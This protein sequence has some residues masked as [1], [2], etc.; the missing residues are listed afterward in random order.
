MAQNNRN[1]YVAQEEGLTKNIGNPM[2]SF[3]E[4]VAAEIGLVGY[5]NMDKGWLASRQNGYV[6]G[7]MTKKMVHFAEQAIANQGHQVMQ[8]VAAT[9]EV[10]PE[11]RRLNEM[12]SQNFQQFATALQNG[13]FL[14]GGQET[15]QQLLQ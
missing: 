9:I 12:A 6:G 13:A 11:V 4:E 15:N 2:N 1:E 7:N 10:S 14:N 3:K 8:T 5:D